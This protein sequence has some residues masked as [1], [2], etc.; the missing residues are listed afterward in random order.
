MPAGV[1]GD[2]IFVY[3]VR[4]HL[5]PFVVVAAEPHLRDV[6]PALVRGDLGRRQ[7]AVVVDDGHVLGVAVVE[8][9]RGLGREKKVVVDEWHVFFLLV[10]KS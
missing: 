4:A 5:A 2:E 9:P 8:F 10:S 7:V 1:A 3:A 6:L